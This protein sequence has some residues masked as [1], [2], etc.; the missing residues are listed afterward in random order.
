M[1]KKRIK[2]TLIGRVVFTFI[3]V[4]LASLI[5][6]IG[7]RSKYR[8]LENNL[9]DAAKKYVELKHSYNDIEEGIKINYDELKMEVDMPELIIKGNA[10]EGYALV[11]KNKI[12]FEFKGFIK[13]PKYTTRGY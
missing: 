1:K 4:I 9:R 11:K 2:L 12:V 10:C 13:C 7:S 3:F 6:F 8:K 5:L